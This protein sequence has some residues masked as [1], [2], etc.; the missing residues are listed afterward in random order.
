[1]L[2]THP[3]ELVQVPPGARWSIVGI[4]LENGRRPTMDFLDRSATDAEEFF[5]LSG[6]LLKG[7][8]FQQYGS[9]FKRL[10][11]VSNVFQIAARRERYLGFRWRAAHLVMTNAFPKQSNSTPPS[12]IGLC[13]RLQQQFFEQYGS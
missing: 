8:P 5:A 11:N 2:Q 12:E 10:R 9:R 4:V 1:V 13:T 6:L 3:Y 7:E